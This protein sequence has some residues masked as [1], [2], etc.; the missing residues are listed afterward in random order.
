MSIKAFAPDIDYTVPIRLYGYSL[1]EA[2][3]AVVRPSGD[4]MLAGVSR[5]RNC[6]TTEG[7]TS[8][9][10]VYKIVIHISDIDTYLI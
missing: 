3:V 6:G 8:K 4:D 10:N 7:K 9:L 1:G 5:L 2:I